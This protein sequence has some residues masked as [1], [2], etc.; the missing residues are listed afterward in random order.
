MIIMYL[1]FNFCL[2]CLNNTRG[3]PCQHLIWS[4]IHPS[5][6]PSSSLSSHQCMFI[7]PFICLIIHPSIQPSIHSSIHPSIWPFI[8]LPIHP[9]IKS[10]THQFTHPSFELSCLHILRDLE[11]RLL[12]FWTR[13]KQTRLKNTL[14]N[15]TR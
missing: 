15:K 1:Q 8:H 10:W 5:I 4:F 13:S 7:H 11:V 6:D 3:D 12:E 2:F 9:P 14:F